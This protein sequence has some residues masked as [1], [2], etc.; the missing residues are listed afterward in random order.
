[1]GDIDGDGYDD[2]VFGAYGYDGGEPDEGRVFVFYGSDTGLPATPDSWLEIDM[3]YAWFGSMATGAGDVNGD[4][5]ADVVV[6][7]VDYANGQDG[8]GAAFVYLG[9][10]DGLEAT[11]SWS[12]ESD[13]AYTHMGNFVWTAGDVNGDAYDDVFVGGWKYS[14]LRSEE[15]AAWCFLGS[16]TGPEANPAW[17]LSGQQSGAWLTRGG[18]A[19]DVNGDGYDDL[20]A[21]GLGYDTDWF[22]EGQAFVFHGPLDSITSPTDCPK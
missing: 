12:Y 5:Y 6:G 10:A 21:G 11:P 9:S 15:G 4:G 19:G 20:I 13:W 14:E 8:E 2:V 22:D 16:P 1:M 7:A 18:T 3:P 17:M